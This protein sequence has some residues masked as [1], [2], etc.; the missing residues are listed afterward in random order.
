M[1]INA[2]YGLSPTGI[3]LPIQLDASSNLKVVAGGSLG[4]TAGFVAL[5]SPPA[6]TNVG[7][8][9]V[10]T[11]ASQVN[12]YRVQNLTVVTINIHEDSAATTGTLQLVPGTVYQ[13]DKP[14]TTLHILTTAAQ[15]VN[16]ANGILVEGWL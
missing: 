2:T 11:F 7:A 1:S 14:V 3:L 16:A 8:D 13:N 4:R 6:N 9:T 12:H 10:L 15:P 5:T